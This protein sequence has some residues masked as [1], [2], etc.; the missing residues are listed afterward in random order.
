[1]TVNVTSPG[2]AFSVRRFADHG[3]LLTFGDAIDPDLSRRIA[4][5]T[6]TLEAES[7]AGVVDFVPSYTTLVV[8]IEP[9]MPDAARIVARVR[10]HWRRTAAAPPSAES[11]TPVVIPVRYGGE[12]GPDLHHV[13][14]ETGLH[15]DE[16]VSRHAGGAYQV[17][18]IGFSPG[19]AFLIGLPPEL[20]VPRRS[21]PRIVVPKGSVGIGGKQTGIYSLETPGGWSLIGR[22][23]L[24][25]FDPD[26]DPPSLLKAGDSVR[27]ER[28]SSPVTVRPEPD[29]PKPQAP[30]YIR[31][32]IEVL[33]PGLQT[34]VQDLGRPGY[35][36][37][38]VAPGGAADR[39]ALVAG[40]RLVGNPDGAAG[41][42]MTLTGPRLR[43]LRPGR[44]A[45]TGADLGARL[46]G[47]GVPAGAR[48]VV[49]PGDEL[50]FAEGQ[51][52]GVRAYLCLGGGIDVPVQ[53]GSRSTDLTAGFG[54]FAGRALR[55]GDWL[56][57]GDER[58]EA[59]ARHIPEVSRGANVIRLVRGPQVER[60]DEESY[61]TF[62]SQAFTVS[63]QSNRLGVRL[64]GPAIPPIGG[65]D[66]ISEGIV[67]GAIQITGEGQPIVMLPARA[68]IGGYPKIATV[69]AADLD[70]LGQLRPGQRLW[71]EDVTAATIS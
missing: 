28:V 25:M 56:G 38:G 61:R 57:V 13:A 27:F 58:A 55:T 17:G 32:V 4:M 31:D 15:P 59:V 49:G 54:G 44:I 65:A 42:E 43:F 19:F 33:E 66:I 23:S 3:L 11:G 51:G 14:Q 70:R 68:T 16:V 9:G 7:L 41:L 8:L 45:I 60:F 46:N 39:S 62:F 50:A 40:N 12:D 67:T 1:M 52:S 48:R 71:F 2:D 18:A 30:A 6:D 63:S 26:R 5:L 36:R 22:T 10:H 24:T 37:L 20:A 21:T 34:S 29:R 35:G 47:M 69:I 53:L 64:E